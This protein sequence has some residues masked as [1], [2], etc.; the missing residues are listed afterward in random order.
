[1]QDLNDYAL[2]AEVVVH[3]GFA[4]AGRALRAPKSTLSRRIATLEARL[5]VRLIERSTRRFR[6]TEIG[7]AF[8]ERC[9]MIMMDVQQA[10]AVVS[11][12]LGEPRG[13][14][15][16]SCP[17][18]LVGAL[19]PTLSS[20][21]KSFPKAKLQVV[22]ADRAV[23]LIDERIDV[24][25]RV[26]AALVTDAALTM[27][28][29]GHSSR[30][31][32]AAPSLAALCAHSDVAV[33]SDLPTLATTDQM[34]EIVWE[35][36]G[37]EGEPRSIRHEPRMT[38]VDFQALRDAAMAGLGV[39]LLPDHSCRSELASGSLIHV[40]P[41]WQTREGIVHLVFTTRRGLP[42]VVRAFIDHL[43]GAFRHERITG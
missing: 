22:A 19:S 14:V 33:L 42:P 29:L 26:R 5:G 17:L 2:F 28:T 4:A 20:F 10:E 27:R 12:A 24:A 34:G 21:M 13:V 18:G 1:M 31:L 25:I 6:V 9:R 35:F 36:S 11:E 15:R 37:P 38:C 32:V 8:Y 7:Q 40:F 43:A 39:A 3:G 30:I 23:G 41:Q 16:C